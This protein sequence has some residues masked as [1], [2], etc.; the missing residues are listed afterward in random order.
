MRIVVELILLLLVAGSSDEY[1]GLSDTSDEGVVVGKKRGR[2]QVLRMVKRPAIHTVIADFLT[3]GFEDLTVNSATE[4]VSMVM[5]SFSVLLP[6]G[7][8]I[9]F[10]KRETDLFGDVIPVISEAMREDGLD[11][12]PFEVVRLGG[13]CHLSLERE[14]GQLDLDGYRLRIRFT[15]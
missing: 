1:E 6:G 15:D 12:K 2:T 4:P 13:G 3:Y 7:R 11:V 14:I 5:V 8:Q 10:A 9:G